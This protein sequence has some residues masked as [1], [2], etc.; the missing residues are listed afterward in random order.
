M[1]FVNFGT[2]LILYAFSLWHQMQGGVSSAWKS[3][4]IFYA[5]LR[6][7]ALLQN[8]FVQLYNNKIDL[9]F[10]VGNN[11][12]WLVMYWITVGLHEA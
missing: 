6:I 1:R 12:Y 7:Y 11:W 3:L 5:L 2:V 4:V 8:N 9:F 10:Y